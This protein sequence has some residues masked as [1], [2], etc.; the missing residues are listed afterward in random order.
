MTSNKKNE[1]LR[2]LIKKILKSSE[3]VVTFAL[4][5]LCSGNS[6][7]CPYH[8]V[9]F[10]QFSKIAENLLLESIKKPDGNGKYEIKNI[11]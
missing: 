2:I 11:M 3:A 1:R 8:A 5:I 10:L 4:L 6:R 7:K 9:S